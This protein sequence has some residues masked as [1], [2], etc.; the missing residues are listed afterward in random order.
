MSTATQNRVR[1]ES[2]LHGALRNGQFELHYQPKVDTATG[3]VNSAEALI[4]WRHPRRGPPA[5]VRGPREGL[6]PAE[7]SLTEEEA[8]QTHSKLA[9]L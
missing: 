5:A 8:A 2:E 7:P 9:G 3:R 1:L 4:R 6:W